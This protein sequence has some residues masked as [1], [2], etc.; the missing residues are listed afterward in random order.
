MVESL[1][2]GAN[3]GIPLGTVVAIGG[4]VFILDGIDSNISPVMVG[5]YLS[6]VWERWRFWIVLPISVHKLP[7][8]HTRDIQT[9][10]QRNHF[11]FLIMEFFNGTLF[12]RFIPPCFHRWFLLA[13]CPWIEPH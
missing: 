6:L 12:L 8:T 5:T 3:I 10:L 9:Y 2:L 13:I 1:F 4:L 11:I 7:W